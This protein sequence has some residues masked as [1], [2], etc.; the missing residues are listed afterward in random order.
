MWIIW[1]EKEKNPIC[2]AF[3]FL[4]FFLYF[5][6]FLFSSSSSFTSLGDGKKVRRKRGIISTTWFI[7]QISATALAGHSVQVSCM[8]DRDSTIC[9]LPASEEQEAGTESRMQYQTLVL[10]DGT[11]TSY[12]LTTRPSTENE[13]RNWK[14]QN[15]YCLVS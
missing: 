6:S 1:K 8:G 10:Q 12:C 9:W 2:A 14:K 3:N 15:K 13:A 4:L 5:S 11:Q 7:P